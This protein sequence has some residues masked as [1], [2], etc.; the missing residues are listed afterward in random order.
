M[1]PGGRG[2]QPSPC[3]HPTGVWQ[4]STWSRLKA[5]ITALWISVKR[6]A[7]LWSTLCSWFLNPVGAWG[8]KA[9]VTFH[10]EKKKKRGG[11]HFVL[12]LLSPTPSTRTQYGSLI[13]HN[14]GHSER[15]VHKDPDH[16]PENMGQLVQD[17]YVTLGEPLNP[18]YAI[19]SLAVIGGWQCSTFG[20]ML[21]PPS[22]MGM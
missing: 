19:G 4:G 13:L 17:W 5:I 7:G 21:M 3:T 14:H 20:A 6:K 18:P 16:N 22:I 12:L 9:L 1:V 2:S 10:K 8:G 15:F 11:W